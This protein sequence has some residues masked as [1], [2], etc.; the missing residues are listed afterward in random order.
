MQCNV[1]NS[2]MLSCTTGLGNFRSFTGVWIRFNSPRDYS[3][4]SSEHDASGLENERFKLS[5][6]AP[7]PSILL[8]CNIECRASLLHGIID[9]ILLK[10]SSEHLPYLDVF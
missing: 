6:S 4:A 3:K 9:Q 7:L 8:S 10:Y 1:P 5:R 2:Y